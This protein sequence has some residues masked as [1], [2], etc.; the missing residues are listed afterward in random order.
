MDK[1]RAFVDADVLF[2]GAAAPGEHGASLVILRMAEI[3]LI[4]AVASLEKVCECFHVP[5]QSGSDRV[6]ELT[7]KGFTAAESLDLVPKAVEIF[8]RCD[9]FFVW[10]FPF[11]TMEDFNQSLFQMVSF[12][13]MLTMGLPTA[14]QFV[15]FGLVIIAGMLVSGDRI[16]KGVE[17]LLRER[18]RPTRSEVDEI[19]SPMNQ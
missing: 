6:L 2:A 8:P 7:K 16:T 15:V 14:L 5:A 12:R 9:T 3:T 1:P 17:Q 13:M 19:L 18:R 4:D 10:G 11:E